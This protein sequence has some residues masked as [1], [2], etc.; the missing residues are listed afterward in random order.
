MIKVNEVTYSRKRYSLSI[1]DM[2]LNPGITLLVGKNG[3]GKS[4]FLQ[5]LATALRPQQG[6]ILY[7]GKT[8]DEALPYI[9][10]QIGFLPTGVELYEEMKT[11]QFLTYMGELKGITTRKAVETSLH[12]MHLQ[13]LQK[14][15]IKS[16]SQGMKQRIRIAQAMLNSPPILLL[17]E[18]L[19]YLDSHERK[20]VV[21]LLSRY[22]KNKLVL[23]ATH[24]LNEWEEIADHVIW[25]NDGKVLYDGSLNCWQ[26]TVTPIWEG[27]L[28]QEKVSELDYNRITYM[29]REKDGVYIKYLS[30]SRPFVGFTKAPTSVEDAYFI[31]KHDM[32]SAKS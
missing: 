26:S 28:Q 5:L 29:K 31:R 12:A 3:A 7:G 6:S 24:D 11:K 20:N 2:Q 21:S 18:P 32:L 19:N 25:I 27:T 17:D 8:I 9:R 22:A 4:T 1:P 16:L 13:K 10:K 23:V 14:K 30:P 15:K